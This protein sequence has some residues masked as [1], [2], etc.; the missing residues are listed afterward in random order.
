[1]GLDEVISFLGTNGLEGVL[2][3]CAAAASLKLYFREGAIV[4]PKGAHKRQS[5][6]IDK[7]ALAAILA[8]GAKLSKSSGR[9]KAISERNTASK[10]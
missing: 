8:R 4:C 3:V 9:L 1:M 5:G 10:R 7:G 6:R 2:T